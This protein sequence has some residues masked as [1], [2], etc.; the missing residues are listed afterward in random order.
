M[1][2]YEDELKK[3]AITYKAALTAYLGPLKAAIAGASGSSIIGVGSGGSFTVASLLCNLH[4]TYTGRVSRPS[5]PLEIICNPTLASA[6]PVFLI[7]A[8]GKNPDIV[9]ALLR[10]RQHSARTIHVLTN[11]GSSPLTERA[12]QLSDI[13]AHIFEITEKDGYLATNSLLMNAVLVARAYGELDQGQDQL[14]ASL[15]HLRLEK[16]TID[17]WLSDAGQF[18]EKAVS[19]RGVIIAYSPL[20][21]S[22]AA[23]LESKLSEAALLYSQLAD[24]RSFAHGRHLWLAERQND[25]AI[26]GLVEPSLQKLW[27]HTCSLIPAE[28]PT[29][30]MPLGGARPRDLLAGLVAQMRLVAMIARRS[31]KDAGHPNVPEFGRKLYYV[32][33]TSLIPGPVEP[34]DRGEQ[35]KYAVLGALWPSKPQYGFMQRALETY[36]ADLEKQVFR[37]VVFD[38]DGTLCHSHS[39]DAPPPEEIINQIIR[40]VEAGVIVGI[41]S[42]RGGS[43]PENLKKSLAEDMWPKVQLGLYN[44]G[45]IINVSGPKHEQGETSEFLSHVARIVRKLKTLGVPIEQI[46]VTHPYQVSVRFRDGIATEPMWF[47]IADALRQAGLDLSSMVRSKHSVDI[48][49]PGVG[50]SRLIAHIIKQ[51][52]IE[53]YQVLTMGDQGAWPGNDSALLEHRFSLSVDLPSRRLDR[54]WNLA[55]SHKRDVDATLWYL[56]RLRTTSGGEFRMELSGVGLAQAPKSS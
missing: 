12:N 8:E 17:Q 16:Q 50:K 2:H 53:P 56:E 37:A 49:A 6:S 22:I 28:T 35:S 4:E 39:H 47:V 42:G 23:D 31:G 1:T 43:V 10:A 48:L 15:D 27:S 52:R 45:Q 7:S 40:L 11:R 13:S 51:H 30:T 38:Y 18:V 29:L 41:A 20:L 19:R 44:C 5:T 36:K 33:L 14:P 55:P 34:S 21:R 46:K 32:D 54:G 26:L 25:C 9:E 3:L 24:L